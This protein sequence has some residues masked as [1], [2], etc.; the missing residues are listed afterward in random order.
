TMFYL[1]IANALGRTKSSIKNVVRRLKLSTP[2]IEK[3]LRDTTGTR[4]KD[5]TGQRF[6]R[7]TAIKYIKTINKR[8]FWLCHCECGKDLVV[9]TCHLSG[10]HTKS[11]GCMRSDKQFISIEKDAY[12]KHCNNAKNR[13]IENLLSQEQ[14]LEIAKRPC[15]YCDTIS[16][17]T[18][19]STGAKLPLNSV[20]RIDNE[21]SYTVE[22]V[23]SVCFICQNMKHVM[24]HEDFLSHL[25]KIK[26]KIYG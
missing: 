14:Y 13:E 25:N 4:F 10:G 18:N 3:R 22:T 2:K 26:L 11:C 8:A 1:D 7:L 17:R 16:I 20:D 5:L 9:P 23:Q 21:K 19:P 15:S 6:S 24:K 12:R